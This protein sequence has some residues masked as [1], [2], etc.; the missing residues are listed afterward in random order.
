MLNFFKWIFNSR[1]PV[2]PG[3]FTQACLLVSAALALPG[4]LLLL[5]GG[6]GQGLGMLLSSII[7]IILFALPAWNAYRRSE[8]LESRVETA[9]DSQ[10]EQQPD[11]ESAPQQ[12]EREAFTDEYSSLRDD[13]RLS[14]QSEAVEQLNLLIN[15]LDDFKSVLNLKFSD[16][17]VTYHRYLDSG[18]KVFDGGVRNIES[19]AAFARSLRSV[20][21]DAL[22]EQ[23]DNMITRGHGDS[24][25]AAAIRQRLEM[26][27]DGRKHIEALMSSNE[28]ALTAMT[29]VTTRL[30]AVT[31]GGSRTSVGTSDM[32]A[33]IEDLHDMAER[34]ER[35]NE[36][37]GPDRPTIKLS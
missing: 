33:M 5:R 23:L 16:T 22:V 1:A 21:A 15:K 17:E 9:H 35:Y 8:R 28:E 2:R 34:T 24:N 10:V 11:V 32:E 19:I 14:G 37:L 3:C 36:Q 29:R 25:A 31:T 30:A 7:P 13:L 20:N 12:T 4:I 18:S 26:M 27:A 6:F